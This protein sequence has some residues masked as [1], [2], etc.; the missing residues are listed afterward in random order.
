MSLQRCVVCVIQN[1]PRGLEHDQPVHAAGHV[2]LTYTAGPAP[3]ALSAAMRIP[4]ETMRAG[5]RTDSCRI[6]A[7]FMTRRFHA[8]GVLAESTQPHREALRHQHGSLAWDLG[9]QPRLLDV[10]QRHH[11]GV[12]RNRAGID[13]VYERRQFPEVVIWR[14]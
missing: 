13:L 5:T 8:G 1:T 12:H 11:I 14:D 4:D 9:A 7:H 6:C 3:N 2:N 10:G